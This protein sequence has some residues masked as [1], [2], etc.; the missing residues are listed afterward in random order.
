MSI[1]NNGEGNSPSER[2]T[3]ETPIIHGMKAQEVSDMGLGA[4]HLNVP[5]R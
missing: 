3:E 4:Q 1:G 5:L 2:M